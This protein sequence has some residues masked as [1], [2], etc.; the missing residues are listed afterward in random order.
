MAALS[1]GIADRIGNGRAIIMSLLLLA[2]LHGSMALL[3]PEWQQPWL[4]IAYFSLH[5][6]LFV[7][8]S[9]SVYAS[10]MGHC[11]PLIAATQFSAYMAVLNLGTSVGSQQL[12]WVRASAGDAGVLATAAGL[13]LAAALFFLMS[14]RQLV[15]KDAT[16]TCSSI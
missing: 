10:A 7:L 8:L 1:G 11:R 4:F 13:C 12:G 15:P 16:L 6:L 14:A 3:Q 5:A 9:V 2:G